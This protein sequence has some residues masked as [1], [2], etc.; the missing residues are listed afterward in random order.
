MPILLTTPAD[1]GIITE[2]ESFTHAKIIHFAHNSQDSRIKMTLAY[3]TVDGEGEFHR[4]SHRAMKKNFVI[5]GGKY[6]NLINNSIATDGENIYEAVKRVLYQWL[7]DN[8][9]LDG[10]VI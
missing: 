2:G 1:G 9:H 10:T 8:G 4:A 3:G 6:N 7:I 5:R